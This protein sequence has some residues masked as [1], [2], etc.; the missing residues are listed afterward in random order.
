MELM[1]MQART[2]PITAFMSGQDKQFLIPV[3]QRNYNW[4]KNDQCQTLWDDLLY[5]RDTGGNIPHFFGSIVSVRDNESDAL[6]IIDGQQR[7]TTVS[8]LLLAIA[9][10]AQEFNDVLRSRD[11]EVEYEI[12]DPKKVLDLCIDSKKKNK[13]KLKLIRGDMEAYQ[14]IV[15]K[16]MQTKFDKTNVVQN[17]KFFY[18]LLNLEN[19]NDIYEA[20]KKLEIVNIKLGNNDDNPQLV[21]ESLNSK[22]LDLTDADKIRNFIL[23][24]LDYQ[25]Q[26]SLYKQYW[27]PMEENV[28][29]SSDDTSKYIWNFLACKTNKKVSMSDVYKQFKEYKTIS[30]SSEN[31]LKDLLYFSEIY[32]EIITGNCENKS[33]NEHLDNLLNAMQTKVVLPLLLDAFAKQKSGQITYEDIIELLKVCESYF[34]RRSV[35]RLKTAGTDRFFLLN[36]KI[37]AILNRYENATYIDVF[38]YL[39]YSDT[40][41]L[42]FPDDIEFS[43]ALGGEDIYTNDKKTCKYILTQIERAHN[44]KEYVDTTPLSIEHIMPQKLDEEWKVELG[45]DWEN[46]HKKYLHTLG[47]L[48]LTGYNSEYGNRPFRFK[49]RVSGGFDFSPLYLNQQMKNTEQ[50]TESEIRERA[51]ALTADVLNI[52]PIY[53]PVYEYAQDRNVTSVALDNSELELIVTNRK[54]KTMYF[55]L[56][57]KELDVT[58]WKDLYMQLINLLYEDNEFKEKM[59]R[60][61]SFGNAGRFANIISKNNENVGQKGEVFWEQIIPSEQVYFRTNKSGYD[62]LKAIKNWFEY[63]HINEDELEITLKAK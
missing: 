42:K 52:W 35:C 18:S 49:K 37:D 6:I 43:K 1:T 41:S 28:G 46:V 54:P 40:T 31:L 48:T 21:F 38:K 30:K 15:D 27:Q 24:G 32:N 59:Q 33:V 34:V 13:L 47:N 22:G 53:K 7:L 55:R 25:E 62:L 4:K 56:M 17:Y 11:G 3:Y 8:L 61:F 57:N 45:T 50:W 39:I 2:D 63:L 14:S 10:R 16:M 5:I 58:S 9:H 26:E 51:R 23:I 12:P 19:I 60:A 36:K 44:S 29:T 20:I